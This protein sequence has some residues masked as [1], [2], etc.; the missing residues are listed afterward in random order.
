MF[1]LAVIFDFVV[2]IIMSSQEQKIN[3]LLDRLRQENNPPS[4]SSTM[5]AHQSN[6]S[7]SEIPGIRPRPQRKFENR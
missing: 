4:R 6:I 3:N 2:C 1:R 5:S 7:N